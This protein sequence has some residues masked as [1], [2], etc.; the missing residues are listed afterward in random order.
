MKYLMGIAIGPVQE[1][2]AAARRTAD[3]TAG[4]RLLVETAQAIA[5]VL[6][7]PN[8]NAVLIFPAD[9][10]TTAPNKL[11]CIVEGEPCEIARTAK[12][13]ALQHLRTQW[14]EAY[15]KRMKPEVQKLVDTELVDWQL[16]N[17]LEFYAAWVPL[18]GTQYHKAR[19]RLERI[20][21]GRKA[22]RNF[23]QPYKYPRHPKSPLDPSMD[24]V[25]YTEAHGK[26]FSAPDAAQKDP[27]LRLKP[28][29]TLDAISLIKRVLGQHGAPSTDKIAARAI[30]FILPQEALHDY[31][32]LLERQD[33]PGVDHFGD[34]LFQK[35]W[36]QQGANLSD[37]D[38]DEI[39]Q[40]VIRLQHALRERG[41]PQEVLSYYAILV[42]DGDRM[43]ATLNQLQTPEQHRSFSKQVAHFAERAKDIVENHR[44]HL[45]YCGGD[46]VLAL[47]PSN[48]ALECAYTLRQNFEQTLADVMPNG[49]TATLSAGIAIVHAMENLQVA[50]GWARE[51]EQQ[52]KRTRDALAVIRQPRSGGRNCYSAP[53]S[54]YHEWEQWVNAF[55]HGLADKLPYELRQLAQEYRAINPPV[56][57]LRAEATRI[58][59]RK[60]KPDEALTIPEWIRS[61]DALDE[62]AEM[63][64]IARFLASYIPKETR[65]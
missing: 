64:L 58:F 19:E 20:I 24:S 10:R 44:G 57:V 33:Q 4:S 11:L 42:A 18:E 3:L 1:F 32:T 51:A 62:F 53:W 13:A 61:V 31:H 16:D 49:S 34:L 38:Y 41:I 52:A 37:A 29:E 39:E 50:I 63:L 54:R 23:Q 15:N 47:L 35:N 60:H 27:Q 46:D 2:I 21:A 8:H 45:V 12:E 56:E 40:C 28:R 6:E 36:R 48:R 65:R 30:E 22:L 26:G 14:K 59:K 7:N 55:R 17:F 5:Q 25:F 9:S 43:G